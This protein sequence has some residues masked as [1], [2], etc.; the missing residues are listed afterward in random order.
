MSTRSSK[1]PAPPKTRCQPQTTD[2]VDAVYVAW[3]REMPSLSTRGA[4]VLARARRITLKAR[5]EI[6][7]VFK[8]FDLDAGEFDV[9]ATLRRAGASFTLRPTE[10]YRSLMISSG[11][12]TDRLGRLEA[13]GLVRRRPSPEDARSLLVELTTD[14]RERT[15]AA[16]QADMELEDRLVAGLTNEEH[17]TLVKLLRKLALAIGA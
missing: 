12:L 14:G 7:A 3:V 2:H 15:E 16:F 8:S 1:P 6:E 10:I 17:A 4:H 13:A 9:L 5:P 11:G